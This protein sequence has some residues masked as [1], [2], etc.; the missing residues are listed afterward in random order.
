M[1]V[2][3]FLAGVKICLSNLNVEQSQTLAP[4]GAVVEHVH[5]MPHWGMQAESFPRSC[6]QL[7]ERPCTTQVGS[8]VWGGAVLSAGLF[9]K[10]HVLFQSLV[11]SS[12]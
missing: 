7:D 4:Q 2:Q 6:T 5:E 12:S 3:L 10:L 9:V 11:I 8:S 1:T